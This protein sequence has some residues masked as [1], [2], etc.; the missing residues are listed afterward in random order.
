M[1][2]AA[3]RGKEAEA[4]VAKHLKAI[5]DSHFTFT[6]RRVPDAHAAGGRFTPQ[7]GDFTA[8]C[9]GHYN[10]GRV[11]VPGPCAGVNDLAAPKSFLIEVKELKH[12]F[13]LPHTSYSP[14][15]VARVQKQVLAGSEAIV[16]LHHSVEKVW[17][18]VPFTI[19]T[20]RSNG[21]SWDL[22]EFPLVDYRTALNEFLGHAP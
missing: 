5:E 22:R 20:D 18:A 19:F 11:W 3:N 1:S 12:A 4:K 16:L 21:G 14:D 13:R 2:T 7:P 9:L 10:A 17:R 15:K 8:F 6:A